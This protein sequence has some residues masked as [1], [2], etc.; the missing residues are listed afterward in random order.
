M[1]CQRAVGSGTRAFDHIP[2]LTS[3][4]TKIPKM[5]GSGQPPAPSPPAHRRMR[6]AIACPHRPPLPPLQLTE[7]CIFPTLTPP[8]LLPPPF[9]PPLPRRAPGPSALSPAPRARSL[10]SAQKLPVLRL[11]WQM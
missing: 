7:G 4:V 8:P 5:P 6:E 11:N 2:S 9:P 3:M 1:H 10:R